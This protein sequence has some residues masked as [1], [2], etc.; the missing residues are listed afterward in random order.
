MRKRPFGQQR[1]DRAG[2]G[3]N[4]VEHRGT[5][6][7]KKKNIEISLSLALAL[8]QLLVMGAVAYGG[9]AKPIAPSQKDK[10]PVCGMFV[11]KYPDFLAEIVFKDG[12][13]AFFDGTKDLFKYY[14]NLK[15]YRRSKKQTDIASIYVTDYYHLTLIDGYKAYYVIGSDIY[16]PM[17]RELVPFEKAEDAK[18]FLK[19]HKGTTCLEFEQINSAIVKS[20]D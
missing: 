1:T 8:A 7:K 20:L 13:V 15:V 3:L 2:L 6:L 10:C 4:A 19:D 14:F 11:A 9:E 18:E 16:G 17:G 12:S 5:K